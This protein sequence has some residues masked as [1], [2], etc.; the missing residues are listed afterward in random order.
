MSWSEPRLFRAIHASWLRA[1]RIVL[2]AG[3]PALFGL[4]AL[5]SGRRPSGAATRRGRRASA[6]RGSMDGIVGRRRAGVT[7]GIAL[8][9]ALSAPAAATA[10]T[11]DVNETQDS[12]TFVSGGDRPA[13]Y[14]DSIKDLSNNNDKCS[15]REAIEASNTDAK[16]DGC[17]A[18]DGP[19]DIVELPAGDYDLFD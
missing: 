1:G 11:I 4:T 15:L 7:F 14:I 8:A 16:V 6:T 3:L 18:G 2:A 19:G 9:F 17:A 10:A 12:A 5:I 13:S